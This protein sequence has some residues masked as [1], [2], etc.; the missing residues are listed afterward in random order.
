LEARIIPERIEHWIEPEQPD[1]QNNSKKNRK[2]SGRFQ[3]Q[4][5]FAHAGLWN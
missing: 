1:G 4:K 3:G 5:R 2:I